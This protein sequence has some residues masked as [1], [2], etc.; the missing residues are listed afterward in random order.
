MPCPYQRGE[1]AN[2]RWIYLLLL[3][4]IFLALILVVET[5]SADPNSTNSKSG[6]ISGSA[7]YQGQAPKSQKLLVVKDVEVCSKVTHNDERLVVNTN[8]GIKDAVVSLTSVKGGKPLESLGSEFV[9]DQKICAYLPHVLILPVNKPLRVLNNDGIL[10]NIH[11]YSLKN[12]PMNLPQSKFKKKLEIAFAMPE[13]VQARCDVHGWMSAWLIVVDHPYYAVTDKEGKFTL[14]DVPPGT[15]TINCW[16]EL[17]GE[18]TAPV[19]VAPGAQVRLDFK[20][21]GKD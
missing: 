5:E 1:E 9:L 20:Y 21:N 3:L 19:T 18:Q 6:T 2:M 17:L 15:Y 7:I 4:G 16:Q 11:T 8:Q 12:S 14:S 10:H 13:K